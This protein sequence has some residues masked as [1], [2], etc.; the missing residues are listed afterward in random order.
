MQRS[1]ELQKEYM[2]QAYTSVLIIIFNILLNLKKNTWA[3]FWSQFLTFN[4]KN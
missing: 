1:I 2:D 4:V 3:K